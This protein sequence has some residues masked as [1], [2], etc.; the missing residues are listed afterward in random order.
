MIKHLINFSLIIF[1]TLSSLV[2][3][4]ENLFEKNYQSQS[5]KGFKS[6]VSSPDTKIMRGWSRESDNIKMLE[7]GY[8][9]MGFSGF[10]STNLPPE[11]ALA[12]GKSIQADM[13]L[14]YDRQIN[15]NTRA[16]AIKRARESILT[17]Q[18]DKDGNTTEIIIDEKD[19]VDPNAKYE[20]YASYWVKLP[21]PTFGTHFIKLTN[22]NTEIENP[23][24]QIIAVIKD[25]PAF[26]AGILRKD[27]ITAVNDVKVN[28]PSEFVKIIQQNKGKSIKVTFLR[29]G[30]EMTVMVGI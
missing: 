18:L 7:D 13:V 1:A 29:K 25:S 27:S 22:Q 5:P 14:I 8:D 9:L 19:L 21:K 30:E 15:E 2:Y 28:D 17:K 23:G 24:I 12:H 10:T 20:F 26:N 3:A 11:L 4:E 6:F 16:T